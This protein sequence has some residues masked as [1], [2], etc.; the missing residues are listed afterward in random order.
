M[1]LGKTVR[2]DAWARLDEFH[3]RVRKSVLYSIVQL[4]FKVF[5]NRT[6]IKFLS[7]KTIQNHSLFYEEIQTR[8]NTFTFL[9]PSAVLPR[10]FFGVSILKT[11][12]RLPNMDFLDLCALLGVDMPALYR[13]SSTDAALGE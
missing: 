5:L 11:F 8:Y 10:C 3:F 13:P 1:Y 12:S 2:H 4:P 7:V 6:N 9:G